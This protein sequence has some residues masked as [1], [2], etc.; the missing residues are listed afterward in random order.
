MDP[1]PEILNLQETALS[2]FYSGEIFSFKDSLRGLEIVQKKGP[3]E[4][5]IMDQS[6]LEEDDS[7]FYRHLDVEKLVTPLIICSDTSPHDKFMHFYPLVTALIEKPLSVSSFTYLV[8]S[9][10]TLQIR[11]PTHVP[12]KIATLLRL[13]MG[14]FNLYL[15]LSDTNFVKIIHQG[16]PFFESDANKLLGK[17][18][19]ELYIKYDDSKDFLKFLEKEL[20]VENVDAAEGITFA[21]DNIEALEQIAKAM[22]WSPTIL[23]SAQ[24]SVTQAVKILSKNSNIVNVLKRRLA[25]PSSA[26]TRHVGLL[27]YMVCAFS[28]SI[29]WIGES[30]QVKLAMAAL[31]H[32]VAVDETIYENLREWD[33][34][35][36]DP[37]DK[38]PETIRYRMHPF[39]ASKLVRT[40]DAF[41]PDVDQIILQ[42]HEVK[43]G[44]GFP[45]AMDSGR[46]GHL[47][48]LFIIVEDLVDFI[49]DGKNIETSITDFITWGRAYYDSGHFKKV[50]TAFEE[51]IKG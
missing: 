15:K 7:L 12:I 5:I 8:K 17:G 34:K 13:G 37:L 36:G 30:G 25:N 31:M 22:Q 43:D 33:K 14:H 23:V 49:D 39:E 41:A 20:N 2:C 21:I 42:H 45:R 10:S 11:Q 48:A 27:T 26:Y 18:I 19:K 51:K 1:N 47:P 38:T 40:L 35:A 6:T 29:G 32:D 4:M 24:R 3:P 9:I 16:E 46:I 28:S 50:F 44:T